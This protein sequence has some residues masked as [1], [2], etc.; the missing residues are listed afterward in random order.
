[1]SWWL[2]VVAGVVGVGSVE[3]SQTPL[4]SSSNAVVLPKS[5]GK[6]AGGSGGGRKA[7]AANQTPLPWAAFLPVPTQ[8]PSPQSQTH[9][10][11]PPLL[12]VQDGQRGLVPI[13]RTKA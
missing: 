7:G 4:S 12:L 6:A 2:V 3:A 9:A 10:T 5:S 11:T 8:P 13:Q 1:M